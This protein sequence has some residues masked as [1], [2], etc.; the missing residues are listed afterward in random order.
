M[1]EKDVLAMTRNSGGI[2]AAVDQYP[3]VKLRLADGTMYTHDGTVTKV[4][5]II[6][7]STGSVS[8]IARFANPEHLLKSGGSG[9]IVVPRTD[10]SSIVIPQS[11]CTT[12]QD[13][14]FV[15]K[16]D[17]NNKV[18]YTEI[19]VN[20]QNDG[21]NYVLTGGLK[22]GDKIVSNGITKLSDQMEIVPITQERYEKKISEQAKSMTAG[23][24]VGGMKK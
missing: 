23:D 24:I 6:D 9:S 11:A 8:M 14:I 18:H 13:K 17:K 7:A 1:T 12:V 3:P 22:V 19:T 10:N 20:P 5:G 2:N 21:K 4:S 16:V 15:Y